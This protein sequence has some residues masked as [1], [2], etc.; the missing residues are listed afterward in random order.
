[1]A[2]SREDKVMLAFWFMAMGWVS[3]LVVLYHFTKPW[4]PSH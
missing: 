1:M 2:L 3:M 4:F